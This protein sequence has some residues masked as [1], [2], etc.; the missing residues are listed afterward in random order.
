M[1]NSLDGVVDSL[2][3]STQEENWI[4]HKKSIVNKLNDVLEGI[5]DGAFEVKV[6]DSF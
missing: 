3:D 4:V 5:L 6:T 2:R 1:D